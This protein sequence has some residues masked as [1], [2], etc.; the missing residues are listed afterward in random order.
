MSDQ[1]PTTPGVSI[2]AHWLRAQ[3]NPAKTLQA[4]IRQ[5][6]PIRLTADG[7]NLDIIA[8]T[9]HPT[10]HVVA[11]KVRNPQTGRR[12]VRVTQDILRAMRDRAKLRLLDA[13][14]ALNKD[15]TAT[16]CKISQL[17]F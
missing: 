6:G 11:F 13:M 4:L 9:V 2:P 1:I 17:P 5:Y 8:Q 15:D 16:V 12:S 10:R 3:T 14:R 7:Y